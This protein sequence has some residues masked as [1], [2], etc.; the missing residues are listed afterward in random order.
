MNLIV[1]WTFIALLLAKTVSNVDK[2]L[3]KSF[4]IFKQNKEKFYEAQSNICIHKVSLFCFMFFTAETF[5][6]YFFTM[7]QLFN[8]LL[9]FSLFQSSVIDPF[10]I[11]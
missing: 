2:R 7:I 5:R 11:V 3:R 8:L 9:H 4:F 6:K 1:V 10:S